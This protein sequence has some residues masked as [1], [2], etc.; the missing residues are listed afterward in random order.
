MRLLIIASFL[1]LQACAITVPVRQ[2][3]SPQTNG[4]NVLEYTTSVG[5]SPMIEPEVSS[6]LETADNH[7]DLVHRISYGITDSV[8]LEYEMGVNFFSGSQSVLG[9]KYQWIGTPSFKTKEGDFHSTVRLRYMGFSGV[10]DDPNKEETIFDDSKFI[11]NLSADMYS[12][13]NSFGY[14]FFDS[15]MGYG[16]FQYIKGDINFRYRDGGPTGTL[17]NSSRSIDGYGAFAGLSL[18]IKFNNVFL[19]KNSAEYEATMLPSPTRDENILYE[20]ASFAT[21]FLFNFD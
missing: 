12:I 4:N 18:N 14:S 11:E 7:G 20:S 19:W 17:I 15:L 3:N 21:S 9:L 5:S 13:S 6:G 8:D 1:L 2:T 10:K 16:G